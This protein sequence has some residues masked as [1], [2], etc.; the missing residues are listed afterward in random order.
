M[1]DF[2]DLDGRSEFFAVT[3]GGTIRTPEGHS[4]TLNDPAVWYIRPIGTTA[5]RPDI[6]PAFTERE[7]ACVELEKLRDK[8]PDGTRVRASSAAVEEVDDEPGAPEDDAP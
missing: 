4:S 3:P 2:G 5:R 7:D 6:A 1:T 8:L